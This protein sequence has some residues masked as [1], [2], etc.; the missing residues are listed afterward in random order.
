V[1]TVATR[2]DNMQHQHMQEPASGLCAVQN[3]CDNT[4]HQQP[5]AVTQKPDVC[6][7]C[8]P[9]P[10][11][12][13]SM[14]TIR[15]LCWVACKSHKRQVPCSPGTYVDTS[16]KPKNG[17]WCG[18]GCVQLV[19]YICAVPDDTSSHKTAM[20]TSTRHTL[21]PQLPLCSCLVAACCA[22]LPPLLLPPCQ[23]LLGLLLHR[24]CVAACAP[25]QVCYAGMC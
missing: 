23:L 13:V 10:Q 9:V 16:T 5:S 3:W 2:A 14:Q 6:T 7:W 18:T 25:Q 19:W 22:P 4:Q 24:F 17:L 20:A 1:D 11:T 15:Q 8:V 21:R 12:L